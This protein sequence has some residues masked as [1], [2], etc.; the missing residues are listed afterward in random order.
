VPGDV[1]PG[2]MQVE[3]NKTPEDK[4]KF[5]LEQLKKTKDLRKNMKR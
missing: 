5:L 3:T 1:S 2:G 4:K